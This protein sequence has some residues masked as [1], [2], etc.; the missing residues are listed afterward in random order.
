VCIYICI[1]T[2][3]YIYVYICIYVYTYIHMYV[4]IYICIYIISVRVHVYVY[5]RVDKEHNRVGPTNPC[6]RWFSQHSLVLRYTLIPTY[7]R[8]PPFHSHSS[9]SR[10]A[11][12]DV[13]HSDMILSRDAFLNVTHSL[14]LTCVSIPILH[15][16]SLPSVWHDVFS[17][18][19][20]SVTWRIHL[21]SHPGQSLHCTTIHH[22]DVTH[23][24]TWCIHSLSHLL[25]SLHS[26]ITHQYGAT[27]SYQLRYTFMRVPGHIRICNMSRSFV[28]CALIRTCAST[29]SWPVCMFQV[30]N[31]SFTDNYWSHHTPWVFTCVAGHI[32]ACDITHSCV[33]HDVFMT[34]LY[35]WHDAFVC[36]TRFIRTCDSVFIM[37]VGELVAFSGTRVMWLVH[38]CLISHVVVPWF[39]STFSRNV[40]HRAYFCEV[41]AG[42]RGEDGEGVLSNPDSDWNWQRSNPDSDKSETNQEQ[43]T[44]CC[45]GYEIKANYLKWKSV[46]VAYVSVSTVCLSRQSAKA[47]ET[48]KFAMFLCR[49]CKQSKKRKIWKMMHVLTSLIPT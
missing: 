17:Y 7:T 20:H 42:W 47:K 11:F 1:H 19:T 41:E 39:F 30:P 9:V 31:A 46:I 6:S 45:S 34:H 15:H 33:W 28:S 27:H 43:K 18:V 2:Y 21:L 26:V 10:D 36:V 12:C 38:R 16:R 3:I 14:A 22:C 13:T 40:L 37:C 48:R 49:S 32:H 25:E 35:V 4:C 23:F 24:V 5:R 44:F 8:I 29:C